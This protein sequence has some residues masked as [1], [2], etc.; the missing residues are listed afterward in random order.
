MHISKIVI[1]TQIYEYQTLSLILVYYDTYLVLTIISQ[2]TFSHENLSVS[3]IVF[4]MI[5]DLIQ[6]I[7]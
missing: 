4:I 3:C 2:N 1:N 6:F 7:F 5:I